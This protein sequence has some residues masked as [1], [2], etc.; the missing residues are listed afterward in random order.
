MSHK[1]L[2]VED[3]AEVRELILTALSLGGYEALFTANGLEAVEMVKTQKPDLIILDLML[4]DLDGIEVC[5][6]VKADEAT[7]SIPIVIIT[8]RVGVSNV[9][10]GLEGGAI[11]YVT[12]PFDVMELMARLRAHLRLQDEVK[13]PPKILR[14]DGLLLDSYKRVIE[15]NERSIKNLTEKEF[16][17]CFHLVR[18]SPRVLD[19]K[20]IFETVWG[21]PFNSKSR[22]IDVHIRS[23]REKLGPDLARRIVSV[24][25]QGYKF[26]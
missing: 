6:R 12:K 8:A 17:I 4:P 24:K 10:K 23:I 13:A 21:R 1:I 18:Q 22:N 15:F 20:E 25:G 2:L 9:V 19:R 5:K 3:D 26:V 14:K 7:K 11:D 16:A